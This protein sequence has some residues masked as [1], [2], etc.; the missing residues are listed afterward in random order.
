MREAMRTAKVGDDVYGEDPTVNQLQEEAAALMGKEAAL[1]VP[2]GSMGNCVS[3]LSHTRPGMEVICEASSH[4]V[5]HE[6]GSLSMFGG[7]VP[8]VITGTHGAM[9]PEEIEARIQPDVYYLSRTG[10]IA[11]ENSHNMAGGTVTDLDYLARV[12]EIADRHGLPVHLDGARIFNAA[13]SLGV[14]PREIA[15]Y[16]DSVMFCLSKGLCAPVGSL[17]AG[18]RE[19]IERARVHR[20]RLGGGMRQCGFLAAAGRVALRTIPPLLA[21]D[22]A[23]IRRFTAFLSG[24]DFL[25][26]DPERVKTNILVFRVD[27]PRRTAADFSARLAEREILCHAFGPMVRLVTYRDIT[28]AMVDRSLQVMEEILRKEF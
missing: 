26:F 4:V 7:L 20:K 3:L 23:K 10:L 17:V 19:F 24:F 16:A 14:E 13:V 18:G 21:G 1:F 28:E 2:T 5:N 22:H 12:R 9:D 6:L 8:R 25:R 11:L 27:H 15:R